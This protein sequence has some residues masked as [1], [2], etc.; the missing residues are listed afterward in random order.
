[1]EH[2]EVNEIICVANFW[3]SQKRLTHTIV[4]YFNVMSTSQQQNDY[5]FNYYKWKE[6]MLFE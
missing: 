2:T 1:M 5:K 6:N 3:L 4:F